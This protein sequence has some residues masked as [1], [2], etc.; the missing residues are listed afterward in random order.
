MGDLTGNGI[1]DL[2]VAN[3]DDGP[4]NPNS[5]SVLMGNGNGT[6]QSPQTIPLP[7]G[8]NFT[9]VADVNGDGKPDIIVTGSGEV[10][11]LLNN[12]NGTFQN[13]VTYPVGVA[14][15]GL[16]VADVNG[17]GKPDI[18]VS[19]QNSNDIG[20]LL[21]N[22]D[23]TFQNQVTYPVT[24]PGS[25]ALADISG[26]GT[27]DLVVD[28]Y[29]SS[30]VSVLA[31]NKNGTFGNAISS[32]VGSN[33]NGLA[34]AEIDGDGLPELAV[35][36]YDGNNGNTVSV[37]EATGD[38]TFTGPVYTIN[39][40]S[41]M[42]SLPTASSGVAGEALSPSV[43]V[44]VEDQWGNIVTGD[45]S[46]VTL[47]LAGGPGGFATGSTTS[48]QAVNGVAT[49]SNLIFDT[50]GSYALS[51]SD[52][53]AHGGHFGKHQR[54]GGGREQARVAAGEHG[55]GQRSTQSNSGGRGGPIWQRSHDRQFD[56]EPECGQRSGYRQQR[57]GE[58]YRRQYDECVGRERCGQLPRSDS[59]DAGGLHVDGRRRGVGCGGLQQLQCGDPPLPVCGVDR[60]EHTG[61]ELLWRQSQL[62]RHLQRTGD[63]NHTGGL[64]P[65]HDG[66]SRCLGD[67][68][69]YGLRQRFGLHGDRQW[70]ERSRVSWS[71]SV[72]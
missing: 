62:H 49:F 46:M 29:A 12:G 65:G 54:D 22:G 52:E 45:T 19:N 17:D 61:V 55:D 60:G 69:D 37:L 56:G 33:P 3:W 16:I 66:D 27:P 67:Q 41:T 68:P 36:N 53:S 51:A 39:D 57:S 28:N 42:W 31:G 4:A 47:T 15:G 11:V 14:Q 30:S 2:V 70:R 32:P 38:R 64:R 21:G 6:F 44:A 58:L 35:A 25:L 23:G 24:G 48:V 18:L 5:L 1:L 26:D 10:G 40:P 59:V 50:A 34:V 13:P 8:P 9:A 72:G 20:V 7:F 63:R 43:E 71:E